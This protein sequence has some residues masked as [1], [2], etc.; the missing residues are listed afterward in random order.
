MDAKHR[1]MLPLVKSVDFIVTDSEVDALVLEAN[2]VRERQPRYNVTLKDDKRYPYLKITVNEEYPRLLLV[3]TAGPDGARYFGPYTDVKS[4]RRAMR[5]LRAAFPLRTCG[6]LEARMRLRKDCLSLHIGRCSGPCVARISRQEYARIVDELLLF[7]SGRRPDLVE[8]LEREMESAAERMEYEKCALLRD[9]I[10]ALRRVPFGRR[11][12]DPGQ[13]EADVLGLAREGAEG[14]VAILKVRD[15]RVVDQETRFFDCGGEVEPAELMA[16][17]VEQHYHAA[18]AA[19]RRILLA[20]E[21]A[22]AALLESWLEKEKGARTQIRVPKRGV[23]RRLAAMAARNASHALRARIEGGA[24]ADDAIEELRE[25]LGLPAAPYVIDCYDVSNI[26][27][28]HAVGSRVVFV[29][30]EPDKRAYRKYS[31]EDSSGGD[32]AMLREIVGRSLARR[33]REG[34]EPPDLIVV[35]GGAGQVSAAIEAA[36]EVGLETVPV[37]GLAKGRELVY[38]PGRGAPTELERRSGALRL[39]QRLRDEAHRFGITYHRSK[40]RSAQLATLLDGVPGVGPSRRTA[41]MRRFGSADGVA[42]ASEAEIASVRGLGPLTAR[43]IKEALRA[44][45]GGGG[46]EGATGGRT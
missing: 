44:M 30:G 3:R 43:R 6:D 7:L 38:V 12:V 18:A 11:L 4:L 39:L 20:Q 23:M 42:V 33:V 32:T 35:D 22:G 19:P 21:C 9:R 26:S 36:T 45:R 10:A 31:I 15:G 2:L 29:A 34:D 37:I 8:D 13:P 14:C 17:F 41:L 28:R 27:G 25:A 40:R 46:G 24:R 16:S 1:A 5:L